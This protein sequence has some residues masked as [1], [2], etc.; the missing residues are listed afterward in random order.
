MI[1]FKYLIIFFISFLFSFSS[2]LIAQELCE[3]CLENVPEDMRNYVYNMDFMEKRC[4]GKTY[5][6]CSS[7][8]EIARY[9]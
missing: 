2:S 7:K 3:E 5:G 6:S 4:D 1:K 9:G 8:V